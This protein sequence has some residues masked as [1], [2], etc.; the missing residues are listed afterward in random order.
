MSNLIDDRLVSYSKTRIGRKGGLTYSYSKGV[1]K[2]F[3]RQADAVLDEIDERLDGLG[4]RRIK[5]S[6][7]TDIIIGFGELPDGAIGAAVWNDRNWEIRLPR[8]YY[9]LTTFTHEVGHV[10]GLGHSSEKANSL[11]RPSYGGIDEFTKKDWR[12]LDA[13]WG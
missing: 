2:I 8:N 1:S 4:F 5:P 13:I 10:L 3:R 7:K 11:M 9:S 6:S 12:A